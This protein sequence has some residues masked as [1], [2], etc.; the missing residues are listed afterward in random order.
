MLLTAILVIFIWGVYGI[1]AGMFIAT[2]TLL[3]WLGLAMCLFY[4][5]CF[6]KGL[7]PFDWTILIGAPAFYLGLHYGCFELPKRNEKSKQ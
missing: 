4:A 2:D 6:F 7:F 3:K 1:V 5:Y